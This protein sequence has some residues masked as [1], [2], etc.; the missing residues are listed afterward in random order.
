MCHF[1]CLGGQMGAR[2]LFSGHPETTLFADFHGFYKL[3]QPAKEADLT[4][5]SDSEMQLSAWAG[6]AAKRIFDVTCVL[7]S[8]PVVLPVFLLV[9]LAVRLT[10]SGP[11]LFRQARMGRDGNAFT[12]FKFRTMPVCTDQASRPTL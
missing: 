4:V 6:S 5:I 7:C 9:W 1:P 12:I 10:S 11:A 3:Q 8:L 2:S